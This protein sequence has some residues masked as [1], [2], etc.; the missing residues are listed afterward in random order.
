MLRR[1]EDVIAVPS[2]TRLA[3]VFTSAGNHPQHWNSFRYAGPLPHA[4]FDPHLPNSQG[5]PTITRE[6]GVLYFSLSVQTCIAEVY[7]AT[8]T[9]DRSTRSPH[10]VLFR[11]RR[12]LRL[13]DLTGLWPTRAGASQAISSGPKS[14]TQAWARAIRASYPELDGLWYRSAMDSGK[15]SVCLWEPPADTALPD[16]PDVL[17]P[18]NHPGLDVPLGRVCQELSY[19]LLD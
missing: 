19:T 12:T 10:L 1:T 4:R 6:H 9:V 13:L 8:S 7:Q 14:R 16:S 17:L 18:L 15:P 5:G 2:G 11:P 3:R